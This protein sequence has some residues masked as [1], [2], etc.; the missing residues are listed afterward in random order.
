MLLVEEHPL[1]GRLGELLCARQQFGG[2]LNRLLVPGW[3]REPLWHRAASWETGAVRGARLH[4]GRRFGERASP[5]FVGMTCVTRGP[6]GTC[7][8]GDDAV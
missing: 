1:R 7:T 6:A 3:P 4:F 8:V 2:L 5:T